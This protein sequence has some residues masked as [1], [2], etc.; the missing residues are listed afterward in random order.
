MIKW[1]ITRHSKSKCI[2]DIKNLDEDAQW[3]PPIP[4]PCFHDDFA[5]DDHIEGP[6]GLDLSY[7]WDDSLY[8]KD[9]T[10]GWVSPDI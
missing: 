6:H 3:K 9:K 8:Q 1:T 4:Y 5:I 7:V 2:E 10:K